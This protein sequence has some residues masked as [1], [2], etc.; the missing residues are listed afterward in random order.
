MACLDDRRAR[1][2]AAAAR[3]TALIC[4]RL[5][6]GDRVGATSRS[7]RSRTPAIALARSGSSARSPGRQSRRRQLDDPETSWL[8]VVLNPSHLSSSWLDGGAAMCAHVRR[9][10]RALTTRA[11]C[12]SRAAG[13]SRR[14]PQRRQTG[15]EQRRGWRRVCAAWNPA[16][17]PRR[18][19][20][21]RIQ[22]RWVFDP[23]TRFAV[24]AA[25]T[26]RC[27]PVAIGAARMFSGC[28]VSDGRH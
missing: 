20:C 6:R 24:I 19:T 13:V 21:S 28:G 5:Q 18:S 8:I 9:A 7:P 15:S 4:D 23:G 16:S 14:M 26:R 12:F 27:S 25:P 11:C 1:R 10:S 22:N 17:A 3:A 2:P